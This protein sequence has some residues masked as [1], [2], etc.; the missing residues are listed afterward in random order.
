VVRTIEVHTGSV[1]GAVP[2]NQYSSA[3][4]AVKETG[5]KPLA[6]GPPAEAAGDDAVVVVVGRV[7]VLRRDAAVV[8][9]VVDGAGVT[10]LDVAGAPEVDVLAAV[11]PPAP[12]PPQAASRPDVASSTAPR[13]NLSFFTD[14]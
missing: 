14:C 12:P 11:R 8:V 2:S 9:V 10:V 3:D 6:T 4:T 5:A 13:T 1:H 7:V